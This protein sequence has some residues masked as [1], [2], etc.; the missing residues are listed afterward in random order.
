MGVSVMAGLHFAASS[1]G[2]FEIGHALNS[3]RRLQDDILEEPVQ[4][5]S[6]EIIVPTDSVGLGVELDEGKLIQYKIGEFWIK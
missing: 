4:Y 1:P 6:G 3:V 5:E 2:L